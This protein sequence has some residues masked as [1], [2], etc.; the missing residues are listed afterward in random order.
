MAEDL[1]TAFRLLPDVDAF[2]KTQECSSAG[3]L[4]CQIPDCTAS[5]AF[6]LGSIW[7]KAVL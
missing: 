4:P 1:Q 7:K 3:E 6:A 5:I 2:I